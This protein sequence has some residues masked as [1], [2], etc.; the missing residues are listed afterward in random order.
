MIQEQELHQ[1]IEQALYEDIRNIGDLSSLSSIDRDTKGTAKLLVKDEGILCGMSVAKA[2]AQK[3][4]DTLQFEE[5]IKEGST[6]K[7]GNIAFYLEGNAISILTAERLI[8]NCM[9]RMS[10]IATTTQKYAKAIEGTNAKVIDT[11]KTTPNLRFLEKYAVTVGGGFN[12]RFGLY[13]MIMLKDNHIDFCGGITKAIQ[14]VRKYL[15][16][17]NLSL[18]IEVETRNIDDVKEILACGGID[19]IMLDN[20]KPEDCKTAVDL[21]N[22]QYE[23][24][25]S[26]GITLETIRAYAETGVDFISVGALTHSVKSLDLSLKATFK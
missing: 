7:F 10:G 14:K 25:A 22:K 18:K 16:D 23:V 6:V 2:I 17:N 9:Q 8:L 12:H 21:I 20:Y 19:R 5:L 11:R 13:D 15:S 1:F 3:V 4:D 24:E 26:G